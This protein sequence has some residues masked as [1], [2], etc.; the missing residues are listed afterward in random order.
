MFRD[1]IAKPSFKQIFSYHVIRPW[2]LPAPNT[3]GKR[4]CA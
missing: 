4:A 1:A 2:G 3:P